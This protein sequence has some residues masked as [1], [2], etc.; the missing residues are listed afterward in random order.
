MKFFRKLLAA[1]VICLL[2]LAA[3][4]QFFNNPVVVKNLLTGNGP[5]PIQAATIGAFS[6]NYLSTN[7]ISPF[8]N[9]CGVGANGFAIGYNIAGTNSLTV[10]NVYFLF[11]TS[12]DGINWNTNTPAGGVSILATPS[13]VSYKPS[14][15]NLLSTIQ[16]LNLG[17]L[18][19]IRLKYISN[20]N[21]G[22]DGT[23]YITNLTISTR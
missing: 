14:Y 3:Q 23:I 22:V 19:A 21:G 17:N 15:T 18:A 16:N 13:G 6:T 11:E 8:A 5:W 10:T 12:S 1:A 20:T 7:G 4:A 2:P 9:I